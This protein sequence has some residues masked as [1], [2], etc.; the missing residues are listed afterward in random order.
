MT[1]LRPDIRR[2]HTHAPG[3]PSP[4]RESFDADD[5]VPE[6]VRITLKFKV[7]PLPSLPPLPPPSP[8]PNASP[9]KSTST[10]T[11]TPSPP[12]S[13][14]SDQHAPSPDAS[15]RAPPQPQVF[16]YTPYRPEKATRPQPVPALPA[17]PPRSPTSPRHAPSPHG[18]A[19][20]ST[21]NAARAQH[22]HLSARLRRLEA[23]RA[24]LRAAIAEMEVRD[25]ERLKAWTED[26]LAWDR[27]ALAAL[28]DE[29]RRLQG[30]IDE[31]LRGE[32]CSRTRDLGHL[33]KRRR[34]D[35]GGGKVSRARI[36]NT[37]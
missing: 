27:R 30:F 33:T 29:I 26:D 31:L 8:Q 32:S 15:H 1:L 10:S 21:T 16:T 20:S 22:Q 35:G 6:E 13:P 37:L 4:L 3:R 19:A 36:E 34:P 17:P 9:S 12:S 5:L 23:R 28:E 25:E 18:S 11:P 24:E 2:R 7:P 14:R